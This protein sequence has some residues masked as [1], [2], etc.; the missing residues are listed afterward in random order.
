MS[1]IVLEIFIEKLGYKPKSNLLRNL[2]ILKEMEEL[3][4]SDNEYS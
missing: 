4:L 1:V 3:H 2:S